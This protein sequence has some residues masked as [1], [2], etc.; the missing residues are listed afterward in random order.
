MSLV[1]RKASTSMNVLGRLSVGTARLLPRG[2]K[3][4]VHNH[5]GLD[6]ALRNLYGKTVVSKQPHPISGGP[7]AGIL[8]RPSSHTSHAHLTGTYEVDVLAAVQ[9]LVKEGMVCY[10]LGASIG[11]ITLLLARR[12][13][14]IYAFEPSPVAQEEMRAHLAANQFSNV[15][16]VPHPVSNTCR[17]VRF[18]VND[19]AFGSSINESGKSKWAELE[20]ETVVLDEFADSHVD[21]DLIKIDIEGEE[22]N[23]LSGAEKLLAR[24][25]PLIVCELHGRDVAIKVRDILHRHGYTL[26]TLEGKP[27]EVPENVVPG[28]FHAVGR[29]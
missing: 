7:M 26:T 23:A 19:N 2:V 8:L 24:K 12:A 27:F 22:A 1:N 21:P 29:P 14:T 15:E 28:E 4:F 11:Y 5:S 25:K 10:D 17:K 16:I 9:G 6:K 20:V 3:Q 13:K 18:A